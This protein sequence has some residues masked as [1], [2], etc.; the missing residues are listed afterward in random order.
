MRVPALQ[1][2]LLGPVLAIACFAALAVAQADEPL[3]LDNMDFPAAAEATAKTW[4]PVYYRGEFNP[5]HSALYHPPLYVY[6]LALWFRLFGSGRAQARVFGALCAVLLGMVTVAL[7]RRLLGP[8]SRVI[9]WAVWPVF[10]LQAYTLQASAILDIDTSIYGPLLLLL[11]AAAIRLG[12]PVDGPLRIRELLPLVLLVALNLWTKLTTVWAVIAILPLL[13]WPR[14]RLWR[15]IG[16][17]VAAC[18]AGVVLFLATYFPFGWLVQA[19][20][21]YTFRFLVD[22]FLRSGGMPAYGYNAHVMVPFS[23]RWTGLLPWLAALLPAAPGFARHFELKRSALIQLRAV[24]AVALVGSLYYMAQTTTFGRAPFKYVFVFWPLV[25]LPL[26]L[27][28]G[29]AAWTLARERWPLV[30]GGRAVGVVL[31]AFAVALWRG[32]RW[33]DGFLVQWTPA[34]KMIWLPALLAAVAVVCWWS[35]GVARRTAPLLWLVAAAAQVGFQA[36]VAIAQVG[37]PHST[38]YDYGQIGLGETIAYVRASTGPDD[39]IVS[40]KD[41]GFQAQRPYIE[42]YAAVYGN[43]PTIAQL[44]ARCED[45]T[46]KLLVFTEGIGQDQLNVNP[47]LREWVASHAMLVA[48]YG[49]YRVYRPVRGGQEPASPP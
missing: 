15:A 2:R 23:I 47:A 32:W 19:D 45:G 12:R 14:L 5:Q 41:V 44:K 34:P 43:E 25:L 16:V 39:V 10:L 24:V 1:S 36:G 26:A 4:R 40:M 6:T 18:G 11:I 7:S 42:N 3:H 35:G 48:R 13:L 22:S 21:R 37:A 33:H 9:D 28:T 38:N 46:V 31:T 29:G 27:V 17:T 49:H 20:V 30:A 8:R